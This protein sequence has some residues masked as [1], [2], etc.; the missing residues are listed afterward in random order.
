MGA[1][2]QNPRIL[3]GRDTRISGGML[4]GA[5]TAGVTSA[6]ADALVVG[7]VPTPAVAYLTKAL[8]CTAGVMISASHNPVEDN[9]IKF[10]G[11]DGFKL[12]DEVED[13]IEAFL[14]HDGGSRPTGGSLGR[15]I[16]KQDALDLYLDYLVQ[17]V[18]VDLRDYHIAVDCANGAAS[19]CTPAVLRRLGAQVTVI[20]DD[21]NGVNINV[22]C[23]STHPSQIQNLVPQVGAHA[24]I[25]HD[26]DGD[27][28]IAV[29]EKGNLVDGDHIL[30]ICGLH[31]LNHGQLSSGK[32]AATVYSNGGLKRAFQNAGGDVVL[33]AAGDRY[34]L[35][36]MLEQGLSLGGEQSGHVIFLEDSTTGDGILTSLKLFQVMHSQKR[37]L[38]E[39][40]QIMETFPQ[41]LI[42]VRVNSRLGWETNP[43]IRSAI[44]HAE[45]Q[46]G[47][48]GR[49]FVR[50]SGTEPVIRVMGE[51]PDEGVVRSA[52]QLV[53][54]AIEAEQG[55][56]EHVD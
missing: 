24:G 55:G 36:A 18:S 11:A 7:V 21:P 29:D 8:G 38:S 41:Q 31:M 28:V 50:A 23:G 12:S 54:D 3:I 14:S 26:G 37:P 44:A 46:L 15:V 43:R 19:H 9:G 16:L 17:R 53:A 25:A 4:E 30:A 52:V 10:F 45:E 6:G 5:L 56:T 20:H 32:I 48:L 34:V 2:V 40:A 22:N 42:N 13:E 27:R 49:L 35:E 47:S 39:L 33:T 51:H 1:H